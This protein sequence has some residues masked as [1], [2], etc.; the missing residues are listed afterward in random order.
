MKR[1]FTLLSVAACLLAADASLQ[2]K[3]VEIDFNGKKITVK[4]DMNEKCIELDQNADNAWGGKYAADSVPAECKGS[5]INFMGY[6]SPVKIEGVETYGE[7]ETLE[8]LQ[9]LKSDKKKYIFVD[10]RMTSWFETGTIPG[11]V[12]MPF[13]HFVQQKKFDKE[14]REHLLALGVS[15]NGDKYDFSKAKTALF[16][17]NGIWC[18]QSPQAIAALIKIGYPKEKIL[19]YRGGMQDWRSVGFTTTSTK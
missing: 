8:F 19:W 15:I 18:G 13:V 1:I 3:G 14:L 2:D 17:C 5:F 16:F 6:I 12:N 7:L 9:K 10:S 11:A 4:R